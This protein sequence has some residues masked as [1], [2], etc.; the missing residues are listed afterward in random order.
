MRNKGRWTFAVALTPLFATAVIA[1]CDAAPVS[2]VAE[3]QI[4]SSASSNSPGAAVASASTRSV[5]DVIGQGPDGAVVAYDGAEIRRTRNGISVKVSMPTPQPGTYSYPEG[6]EAGHPEA[7]TLWV[8][9]FN[10]PHAEDWDGAFHGAGHVV[11]GPNL[12]LQGHISTNTEPFVGEALDNPHG[13]RIHLAVAPH[14]ALAPDRL[15]G[16]IKTPSGA[17]DHWWLA[18]F[19]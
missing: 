7:F 5:A 18:F 14:G 13:A 16:Q 17:P 6:A 15:P 12:T 1:G 4:Q 11:G 19:D 9:V 8:F 2:P 3:L 10:D